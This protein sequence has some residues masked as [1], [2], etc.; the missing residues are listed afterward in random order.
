MPEY[1]TFIWRKL[2]NEKDQWVL[3]VEI[4]NTVE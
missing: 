4:Q 2:E 3:K 1:V